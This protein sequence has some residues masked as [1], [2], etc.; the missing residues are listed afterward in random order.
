M[1]KS[2]VDGAWMYESGYL[3]VFGVTI[4]SML[5]VKVNWQGSRKK[6]LQLSDFFMKIMHW[7]ITFQKMIIS[8][9]AK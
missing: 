6:E 3:K 9:G 2:R 5:K 4:I 8:Y 7:K 1:P